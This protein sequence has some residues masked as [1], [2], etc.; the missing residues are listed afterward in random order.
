MYIKDL[1]QDLWEENA[2]E[3]CRKKEDIIGFSNI[4]DFFANISLFC[5]WPFSGLE[6]KYYDSSFSKP[7]TPFLELNSHSHAFYL[8]YFSH[9]NDQICVKEGFFTNT[10]IGNPHYFVE[11]CF[12]IFESHAFFLMPNTH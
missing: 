11:T 3:L 1:Q 5:T 7:Y 2:E 12:A 6:D 4:V 9:N 10:Y 8:S